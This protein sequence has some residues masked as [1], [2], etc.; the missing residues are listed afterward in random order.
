MPAKPPTQ[1]LDS[2]AGGGIRGLQ[3]GA[4]ALWEASIE[5]ATRL[6]ASAIGR[7][8]EQAA[9]PRSNRKPAP[10]ASEPAIQLFV[11]PPSSDAYTSFCS[12]VT[13]KGADGSSFAKSAGDIGGAAYAAVPLVRSGDA[14][15][16]RTGGQAAVGTLL[17]V[18]D[19]PHPWSK[20]DEAVVRDVAALLAVDLELHQELAEHLLAEEELQEKARRDTRTGVPN[21]TLFLDRLGHAIERGRRH[22]DF[23]FAVLALD[24]DRFQS[25]NN[26]LGR[27]AGNEVLT[28]IA[29]RLESCVRGEDLIARSGGDEF[30]ILLESLSDDSDGSRVTERMQQAIAAPIE[31]SDGEVYTSASIGIVLSSSG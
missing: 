24:L 13:A 15:A 6:I 3:H 29:R 9:A 23:R 26:S 16:P 7:C 12:D 10:S 1:L 11:L 28:V 25:I 5:H 17:V 4:G 19:E 14:T 31:T 20:T 2:P 27:D 8:P 22:K 21:S 30:A 18:L